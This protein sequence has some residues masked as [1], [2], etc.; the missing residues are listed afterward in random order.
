MTTQIPIS[1]P[2]CIAIS[3]SEYTSAP[4]A[5]S[6]TMATVL[7]VKHY[8]TE[9]FVVLLHGSPAVITLQGLKMY[10]P[11][12]PEDEAKAQWP[13][14]AIY[15]KTPCVEDICEGA[16]LILVDRGT[17]NVYKAAMIGASVMISGDC[18]RTTNP[19]C[20]GTSVPVPVILP[21]RRKRTSMQ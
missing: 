16:E 2:T 19:V 5:K 17:W 21:A 3:P 12:M 20:A 14:M 18:T 13:S 11:D 7:S 9:E 1:T 8:P 4:A 6:L 10:V 15:N